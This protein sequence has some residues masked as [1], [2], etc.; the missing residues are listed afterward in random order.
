MDREVVR[1]VGEIKSNWLRLG[2]LV[3]RVMETRALAALG[4]PNVHA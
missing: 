1:I 3:L 2:R 4:F